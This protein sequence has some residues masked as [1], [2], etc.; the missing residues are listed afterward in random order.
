M[1]SFSLSK[2]AGSRFLSNLSP[3]FFFVCL[4]SSRERSH[5]EQQLRER[6]RESEECRAR[7]RKGGAFGGGDDERIRRKSDAGVVRLARTI[8]LSLTGGPGDVF[9]EVG[10]ECAIVRIVCGKIIESGNLRDLLCRF[11]VYGSE[12]SGVLL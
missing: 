5:R 3:T 4:F 10:V 1:Q 12:S 8:T 11:S 6:E 2:T 7:A 9:A